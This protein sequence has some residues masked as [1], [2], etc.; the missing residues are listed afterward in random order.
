MSFYLLRLGGEAQRCAGMLHNRPVS[1]GIDYLVNN[2]TDSNT[3][4]VGGEYAGFLKRKLKSEIGE[5]EEDIKE[6]DVYE[7]INY[8]WTYTILRGKYQEPD[9]RP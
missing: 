3:S 1:L 6:G 5:N 7:P 4:R 8:F 2:L 9:G